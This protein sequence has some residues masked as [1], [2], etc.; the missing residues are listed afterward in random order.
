MYHDHFGLTDHPFM[1]TPDTRLFYTGGKRGAI[2]DALE[3]AVNSGEGIVKVVGEVG[4]GKT[5][6]CRMLEGRLSKTV[7]TVFLAN[8]S[9]SPENIFHAIAV[10]LRIPLPEQ[11]DRFIAMQALQVY[12]LKKHAAGKRVVILVEEAQGMPLATLEEIRLLSNL[13]TKRSKLLQLVLFG[14]PELDENLAVPAIRQLRERISYQFNL[15]PLTKEEVGEYLIHRLRGSGYRGPNPFHP[16]ACHLIWRYSNGLSRRVNLLADKSLLATFIEKKDQVQPDHVRKAAAESAFTPVRNWRK[17]AINL[18]VF[19]GISM[20]AGVLLGTQ[21]SHQPVTPP[22]AAAPP[23]SVTPDAHASVLNPPSQALT[24]APAI[25]KK[26]VPPAPAAETVP[27]AKAESEPT[28]GKTMIT[29]RA[30]VSHTVQPP[31]E[32]AAPTTAAA[33]LEPSRPATAPLPKT[34]TAKPLVKTVAPIETKQFLQDRIRATKTWLANTDDEH[35]T[36]QLMLIYRNAVNWLKPLAELHRQEG[37]DIYIK[38]I[39]Y[40]KRPHFKVYMNS[41][42]SYRQ[43]TEEMNGLPPDFLK[44]GPF[45]QKVS[46][47]HEES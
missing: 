6:L 7:E 34:A 45:I 12:L 33:P 20:P 5:M 37:R 28:A 31:P 2:L 1:N 23:A 15:S 24:P 27:V 13:E 46:H 19:L 41:Y 43:A 4:S 42:K 36:V 3:Y 38:P 25:E 8:P 26:I 16:R 21:L 14:Q 35:Y 29:A 30:V 40:K 11:A 18:A 22:A 39:T 9:L 10:E 47:V 44:N 17:I 32:P